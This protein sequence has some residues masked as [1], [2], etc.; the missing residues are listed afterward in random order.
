MENYECN[1]SVNKMKKE[2]GLSSQ[3]ACFLNTCCLDVGASIK[4]TPSLDFHRHLLSY[5]NSSGRT[6][7]SSVRT[8][9]IR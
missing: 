7:Q 6:S 8:A 5:I 2:Q 1:M 9:A 4:A 3:T